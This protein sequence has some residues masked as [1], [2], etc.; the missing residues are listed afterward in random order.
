MG[1]SVGA[2]IKED[3]LYIPDLNRHMDLAMYQNATCGPTAV[4]LAAHQL[5]NKVCRVASF[6]MAQ[7]PTDGGVVASIVTVGVHVFNHGR[8][9]EILFTG[10][11][12]RISGAGSHILAVDDGEGELDAADI[13]ARLV[14]HLTKNNPKCWIFRLKEDEASWLD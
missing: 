5:V 11:D 9:A 10:S 3:D 8:R 1:A 7:H 12:N 6:A 4:A 14:Y 13:A 2:V